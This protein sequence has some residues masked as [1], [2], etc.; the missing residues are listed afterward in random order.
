MVLA[1]VYITFI[2]HSN[3]LRYTMME[4]ELHEILG[5]RGMYISPRGRKAFGEALERKAISIIEKAEKVREQ[6]MKKTLM[7]RHI[8]GGRILDERG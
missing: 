4:K 3:W 5:P 2:N 8:K 6:S 7:A 1:A